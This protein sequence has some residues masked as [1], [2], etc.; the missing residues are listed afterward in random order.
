MTKILGL[1][2]SPG[3]VF[4][5]DRLA[6]RS[7]AQARQTR[8]R[9]LEAAVRWFFV[10]EALQS[11]VPAKEACQPHWFRFGSV[12]MRMPKTERGLG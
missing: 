11:F 3:F 1:N 8:T 4:I 10:N 5:V 2:F 7:Q 12:A 6:A 9:G